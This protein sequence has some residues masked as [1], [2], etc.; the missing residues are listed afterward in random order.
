MLKLIENIVE[1]DV[2]AKEKEHKG[3]RVWPDSR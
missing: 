1:K 3:Y 2:E